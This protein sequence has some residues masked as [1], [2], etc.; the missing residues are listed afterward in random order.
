MFLLN[1]MLTTQINWLQ[2]KKRDV[3]SKVI[4]IEDE[5][6]KKLLDIKMSNKKPVTYFNPVTKKHPEQDF[7]LSSMTFEDTDCFTARMKA[8]L[9]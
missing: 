1:A 6:F 2:K 3:G 9:G 8:S 5:A 4:E 7:F